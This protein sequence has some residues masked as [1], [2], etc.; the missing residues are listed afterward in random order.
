MS[1]TTRDAV[2]DAHLSVC[3]AKAKLDVQPRRSEPRRVCLPGGVAADELVF[4]RL[5]SSARVVEDFVFLGHEDG[6]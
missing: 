2:L 6:R 5:G 4:L 1:A 3:T